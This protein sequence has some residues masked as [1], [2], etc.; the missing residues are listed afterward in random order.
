[1]EVLVAVQA[2]QGEE[3]EEVEVAQEKHKEY[4]P[5]KDGS[6]M[7]QAGEKKAKQGFEMWKLLLLYDYLAEVET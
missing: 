1:M 5:C 4:P 7:V 2:L 3:G 6:K